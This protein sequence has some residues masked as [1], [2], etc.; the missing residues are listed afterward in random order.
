MD[1]VDSNFTYSHVD[2][3]VSPFEVVDH[4]GIDE[5]TDDSFDTSV[6]DFSPPIESSDSTQPFIPDDKKKKGLSKKAIIGIA[7]GCAGFVVIAVTVTVVVYFVVRKK[8]INL[9]AKSE[10]ETQMISDKDNSQANL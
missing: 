3:V 9:Y 4:S 2:V 6:P 10:I 5:D 8:N 7:C 1:V